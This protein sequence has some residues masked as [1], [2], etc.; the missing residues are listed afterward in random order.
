M[1]SFL[2]RLADLSISKLLGLVVGLPGL[3]MIAF[4]MFLIAGQWQATTRMQRLNELCAFATKVADLVHETQKER[5][6]SAVFLNSNGQQ[7]A[8]ELPRQRALTTQR[9]AQVKQALDQLAPAD[10]TAS[11]R[12]VIQAGMDA[13]AGLDAKRD[14]ILGKRVTGSQSN[15]F[16]TAL[17]GT[18]LAIPRETVKASDDPAISASLLAYSSFLSAKERS[19]Q[20]RALGAVGFAAGRFTSEQHRAYLTA[21]ADQRSFFDAFAAYATPAQRA[22]LDTTVRGPAVAEVERDRK[23]ATEATPGEPLDGVTGKSWYEA[24]TARINL[25]KQVEDSLAQDV[26]Q[27]SGKA[28][29]IARRNLIAA[30]VAI[31]GA[32]LA[33]LLVTQWLSRRI[34]RPITGMTAAMAKLADGDLSLTVPAIEQKNEIGDMA[35]AVEVFKRNALAAQRMQSE[36]DAARSARARRQDA[37]DQHTQAFGVDITGVMASL[38]GSADA[39]RGASA[40]MSEAASAVHGE[41]AETAVAAS[42]SS[43]DLTA[44]ASAVEEL[45]ASVSEIS[46]QVTTAADVTRQ[47]VHRADTSH[48]TM[49]GLSEAAARIGDVVHLISNIAGQT[50]LLALNATIEAA[51]AGEAGKGF[52][53]VAGEV[54]ALAAQT[55]RA[56]ADIGSHIDT[57]RTAAGEAVSAMDHI[58]TIIGQLDH[59]SAAI[60]AAVNQQSATTRE[61]AGSIQAVSDATGRTAKAMSHVVEVAGTGGTASRNVASGAEDIAREAA[62]LRSRVDGF[63]RAI[64]SESG[65]RRRLERLAGN[66]VRGTLQVPGHTPAD[67][68]VKDISPNGAALLGNLTVTVGRDLKLDLPGAGGVITVQATRVHEGVIAVVFRQDA[69]TEARVQRFIAALTQAA[70]A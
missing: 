50:N 18:L 47:A 65:E 12:A 49:L 58:S 4:A 34:T 21:V 33:S 51:R 17:N 11:V 5:G 40:S 69:E 41:A 37:M 30:A 16:F 54:K 39:L 10:Y 52:A 15:S 26:L 23:I 22:L 67:V 35:R 28:A 48:A 55:A 7:L 62:A 64:T 59:V 32:L 70:A 31:I 43:Q 42:K 24:T 13:L 44:V 3:S 6:M 36:Q 66:A 19:G 1:K 14:D 2:S 25:M 57:V 38:A 46:R 61:I 56:T 9:L 53:V 60:S 20:E 8:S 29:D 68:V 45:T 27:A 63:L